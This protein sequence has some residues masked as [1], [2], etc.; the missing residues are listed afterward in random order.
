MFAYPFILRSCYFIFIHIFLCVSFQGY[1]FEFVL[2]ARVITSFRFVHE[3]QTFFFPLQENI[4]FYIVM[5]VSIYPNVFNE[6]N[7][8]RQSSPYIYINPRLYTLYTGRWH[9]IK[10]QIFP[11]GFSRNSLYFSS[12]KI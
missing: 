5:S 3:N 7:L 9:R 11:W 6:K 10:S 1:C 8:P 2:C 4:F 12:C